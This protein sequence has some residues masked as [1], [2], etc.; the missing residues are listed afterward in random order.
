MLCTTCRL[1]KDIVY[2]DDLGLHYCANCIETAPLPSVAKAMDFLYATVPFA[3]GDRVEC[4]TGEE[5]DGVGVI[6]GVYFDIQ[7]GG[8]PVYPTFNVVLD[9]KSS[10]DIPGEGLYPENCLVRVGDG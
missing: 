10:E 5:F 7:H 3:V 8:T 4:R 1:I 6:D 9:E 2:T